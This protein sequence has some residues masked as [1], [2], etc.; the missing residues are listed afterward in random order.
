MYAT[1]DEWYLAGQQER[2]EIAQSLGYLRQEFSDEAVSRGLL[3]TLGERFV[4]FQD[5]VEKL[6]ALLVSPPP[7]CSSAPSRPGMRPQRPA[8]QIPLR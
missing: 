3:P 8:A 2:T 1:M 4:P 6:A 7:P 5:N